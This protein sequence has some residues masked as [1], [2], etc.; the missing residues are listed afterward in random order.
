MTEHQEATVSDEHA[1]AQRLRRL[2]EMDG[3]GSWPPKVAHGP[4]WPAALRPYHDIYIEMAPVLPVYPPSVD[5]EANA[6]RIATF[7]SRIR[8]LFHDKIN[9]SEVESLL[10]AAER[11]ESSPFPLDAR[12]GFFACIALSR[13]AYRWGVIP[14]V[15]VAQDEKFIDMPLELN[16][17]WAFLQRIYGVT[18]H[19]GNVTSNYF[20]N[21]DKDDNLVYEINHGMPKMIQTAEHHFA[22][23]FPVLE[24]LALPIYHEMVK[25]MIAF[26]RGQREQCLESLKEISTSL[27]LPL[28]AFYDTLVNSKIDRSVWLS[29]CQGFQGWAAGEM[30]DGVYVE[31]DGLSGNQLPFFHFVDA[32]IG[33]PPYLSEENMQR[34]IPAAQRHFTASLR[35]HS[36]RTKAKE[37]GDVEIEAEMEKIVKQMRVFREAHRARARPYLSAPAP[38]RKVMTAGKSVLESEKI[39]DSNAAIEFLF[40]LLAGRLKQT[41]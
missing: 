36:F 14:V 41:V 24:K 35:E 28:K 29:Y 32:F 13:H 27:R 19:G 39:P 2:I 12:N 23:I 25:S 5:S 40:K 22:R 4:S 11:G 15:K 1:T 17:P 31:Y 30:K 10:I 8:N 21:F 9:L 18:S 37:M 26:D 34:Y 20:Y 7:R 6:I 3:A 33:M 38:E 16:V